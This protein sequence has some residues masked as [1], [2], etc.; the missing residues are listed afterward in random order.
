M[1]RWPRS[2][3]EPEAPAELIR[4]SGHWIACP[5]SADGSPF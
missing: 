1:Q 4:A 3:E 5:P 2:E